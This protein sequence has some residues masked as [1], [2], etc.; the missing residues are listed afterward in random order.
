MLYGWRKYTDFKYYSKEN[1]FLE[2]Q[3]LY[4]LLSS[5]AVLVFIQS[6]FYRPSATETSFLN[7][8]HKRR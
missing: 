6:S 7:H 2:L 5:I 1:Y 3:I 4:F 8:G